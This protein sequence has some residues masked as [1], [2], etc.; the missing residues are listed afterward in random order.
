MTQTLVV[1]FVEIAALEINS[2]YLAKLSKNKDN[3]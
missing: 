1:M 2:V 3:V